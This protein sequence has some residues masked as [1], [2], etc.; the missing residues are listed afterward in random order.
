MY[1][2]RFSGVSEG[3]LNLVAR[4]WPTLG[5][6]AVCLDMNGVSSSSNLHIKGAKG[7]V[8]PLTC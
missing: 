1:V 4:G 2:L 8:S 5:F 7:S 3:V 6:S